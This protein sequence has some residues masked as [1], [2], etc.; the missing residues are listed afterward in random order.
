MTP[1]YGQ[2]I[3]DLLRRL[4][5]WSVVDAADIDEA[6]Y[7]LSKKLSEVKINATCHCNPANEKDDVQCWSAC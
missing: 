5:E 2:E 6:K 1:L 4:Y 3:I 7:L